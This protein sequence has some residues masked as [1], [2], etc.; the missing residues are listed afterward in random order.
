MF[1]RRSCQGNGAAAWMQLVNHQLILQRLHLPP[2][3]CECTLSG[4]DSECMYCIA[5][6]QACESAKGKECH[7]DDLNQLGSCTDSG[8]CAPDVIV[9]PVRL[10]AAQMQLPSA[11]TCPSFWHKCCSV[12]LYNGACR[13]EYAVRCKA[14]IRVELCLKDHY[15]TIL[16][17]R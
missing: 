7:T 12:Q 3:Q 1:S 16:R 8:A 9:N 10:A 13:L 15:C 17:A 4:Q 6:D 5:T 11:R 14:G 2:L